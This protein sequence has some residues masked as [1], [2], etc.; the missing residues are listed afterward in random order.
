MKNFFQLLIKTY[1][2]WSDNKATTQAAA[3]SY[4]MIFSLAPFI[5]I[6]LTLLG[7][8]FSKSDVNSAFMQQIGELIGPS[9]KEVFQSIINT[10]KEPRVSSIVGII[11]IATMVFGATGVLVQLKDALNTIWKVKEERF[12]GLKGM[13]KMR[14][15]AFAGILVFVFLLLVS[16]VASTLISTITGK[17]ASNTKV[18]FVILQIINQLLSI[19]II[20]VLFALIFKYLP[21]TEVAWKDVWVGALFT[22]ILFNIGKFAIGLYIGNSNIGSAF[23]AA[24]SALVVLLWIYFSSMIL[25]FGAMF[26]QVYSERK[27]LETKAG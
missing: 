26:T 2:G 22:S 1:K 5:T 11:S 6:T 25:L 23:G 7:W 18:Y 19:G 4:Y 20:T 12:K 24:G 10:A 9:G 17:F 3:L 16:L 27:H 13:V 21:D 8:F 14:A 15:L